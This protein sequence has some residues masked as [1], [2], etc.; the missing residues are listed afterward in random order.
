[1]RNGELFIAGRLKDLIVIDGRNLYPHDIEMTVE[2][3]HAALRPGC[4][5][6]FSVDISDEEHLIV[7]AELERHYQPEPGRLNGKSRNYADGS[8]P[9][10]RSPADLN[11]VVRAIRR[12]VAEEHDVRVHAVV[13]LRVGSIPKTPS[14]KVQRRVC[15]ASF[16]DGTLEHCA[17]NE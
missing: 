2:Q 7:A 6:A 15:E 16:L 4:C 14:G 3:S 11:A 17:K 5:V 12:A 13:L 10:G 1:M 8:H 9:N